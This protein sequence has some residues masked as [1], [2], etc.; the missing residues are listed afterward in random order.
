[1]RF[2][3]LCILCA[4]VALSTLVHKIIADRQNCSNVQLTNKRVLVIGLGLSGSA[5]SGV[6][7][8][9]QG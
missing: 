1:M 7:A 9:W 5:A 2:Y 6:E 3:I 4:V 8:A